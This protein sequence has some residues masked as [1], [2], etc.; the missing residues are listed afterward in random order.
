MA[1][2]DRVALSPVFFLHSQESFLCSRTALPLV[3][4][5]SSFFFHSW[6]GSNM[7]ILQQ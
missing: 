5:F 2:A 7:A 1:L 6:L 3:F 4:V